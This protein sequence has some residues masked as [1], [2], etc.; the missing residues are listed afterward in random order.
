MRKI[1]VLV[2]IFLFSLGYAQTV[3]E[4]ELE[5]VKPKVQKEFKDRF[6]LGL[7]SSY[8]IDFATTPLTTIGEVY[9]GEIVDPNDPSKTIPNYGDIPSQ[10]TYNSFFSMGIEPRYNIKDFNE[11]LAFAV[12]APLT[13]GFGQSFP[14]NT[15][16]S[17]AYGFGSL[18]IPIMAKIYLGTASTYESNEDFGLSAGLGFEFNKIGLINPGASEEEQN[19]LK[20]WVMPTASAAVHFWRGNSP[21]EVNVKYGFGSLQSYQTDQFGQPLVTGERTTRANSIKLTLVYLMNY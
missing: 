6:Y 7:V 9:I 10:T 17:G 19:A 2:G 5:E 8:Y 18:Q 15:T 3:E 21:M 20:P 1:F 13:I 12:S 16:V 11:N 4:D 14:A